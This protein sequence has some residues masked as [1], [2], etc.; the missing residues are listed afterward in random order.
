MTELRKIA[1]HGVPR[2]GTSWLGEILNSSPHS[3]YKYQPLFSYALKGFLNEESST[4]QIENFWDLLENTKDDFMDQVESRSQLKLPTFEKSE[5]THIVYKEVRYHHIL[6]NMLGRDEKMLLVAVLR[7]PLAIISSW[8]Q[9]PREFRRD[10][11]WKPIEEWRFAQIK[12][13]DRP[14]EFFG[15]EKWKQATRI[16]L[17]LKKMFPDRVIMCP[18]E[19]MVAD[20]I[21][22]TERL[23]E[24]TGLK[25][26]SQ[27]L[28]FLSDSSE[29]QNEDAY[30]VFKVE[31]TVDKWK[32][33]LDSEIAAAIITD[34]KRSRLL[35][36]LPPEQ[37]KDFQ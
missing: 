14:E 10:L 19:K 25:L 13:C 37:V 32:E 4:R 5:S 11:G 21:H 7:N 23:F 20:T 12:N 8:I 34:M 33:H 28:Q 31:R 2:S 18:Y 29:R 24:F 6:R 1:V 26:T 27:T 36:L 17:E 15:Y 35:D 16:F 9:A 30:S 22:E 3:I